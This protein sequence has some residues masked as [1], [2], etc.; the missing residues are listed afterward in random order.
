MHL[1]IY[2]SSSFRCSK[3]ARHSIYYC[4]FFGQHRYVSCFFLWVMSYNWILWQA[5][6]ANISHLVPYRHTCY[7]FKWFYHSP[8]A[9]FP[10]SYFFRANFLRSTKPSWYRCYCSNYGGHW[11][12]T[13][14]Y[15]QGTQAYSRG[16]RAEASLK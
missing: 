13:F 3:F 9:S 1:K 7:S 11:A 15:S 12:G 2:R 4:Y 5:S 8:H 6:L 10:Q 14:S 16:H